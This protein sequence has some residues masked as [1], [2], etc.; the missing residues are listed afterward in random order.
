M[1]KFGYSI[2]KEKPTSRPSLIITNDDGHTYNKV[3]VFRNEES[4]KAFNMWL[5]ALL[6]EYAEMIRRQNDD[7][8]VQD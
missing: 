1:N 3:A 4:V 8:Q 2:W 7:S 5:E 6:R